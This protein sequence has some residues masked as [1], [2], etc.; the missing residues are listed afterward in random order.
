VIPPENVKALLLNPPRDLVKA[1]VVKRLPD[2][3]SLSV[4]D[5]R[6]EEDIAF[7][8]DITREDENTSDAIKPFVSIK[9]NDGDSLIDRSKDLVSSM[10]E[11]I[12]MTLVD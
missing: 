12:L 5:S 3:A 8:N 4:T 6:S 9:R 1:F 10:G 2:L 7:E 11:L